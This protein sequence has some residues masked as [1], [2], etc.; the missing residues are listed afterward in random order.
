MLSV[1]DNGRGM[2]AATLERIFEP[3]FT[4]KES[5]KG[6]GLGLAVVHSIVA[7]HGGAIS[8]QSRPGEGSLF[9][10]YLPALAGSE[11]AAPA[12]GRV[13][14]RGQGEHILVVD[15]EPASGGVI[16]LLIERLGYRA[17]YSDNPAAA[18]QLLA[19]QDYA[20]L[21]TDLAMPGL[22]GDE[23]ARQATSRQPA[24]R[25]CCCRAMSRRRSSR[26]C[27][28]S[29]CAKC[30]PSHRPTMSWRRRCSGVCGTRQAGRGAGLLRPTAPDFD[31]SR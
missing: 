22:A 1:R 6:T 16:T 9:E 13:V 17:T 14:A 7:A 4:T 10:V 25:S 30:S 28:H 15:D 24:C 31:A 8:V 26:P 3:F 12:A 5:G 23:L 20:M 11:P 18:L 19:A 29:A 2:D 27:A 21:V